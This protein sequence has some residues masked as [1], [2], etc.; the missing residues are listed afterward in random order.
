MSHAFF[1]RV[2]IY[3]IFFVLLYRSGLSYSF[4]Q[5][6]L[7]SAKKISIT[8]GQWLRIF[9]HSMILILFWL[10]WISGLVLTGPL[11]TVFV[12]LHYDYTLAGIASGLFVGRFQIFSSK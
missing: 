9:R 12:S 8:P 7:S 4:V 6:P 3:T 10:T 5:K 11:R 1:I 2:P